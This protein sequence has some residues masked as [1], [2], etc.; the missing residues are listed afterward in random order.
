[1]RA[2]NPALIPRNHRI[3]EMIAAALDGDFAPLSRLLRVLADPYTDQPDARD[4]TRPPQ[5]HEVV[6]QTFCGT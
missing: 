3:E 6:R 5:A 2:A 1:M 4:L